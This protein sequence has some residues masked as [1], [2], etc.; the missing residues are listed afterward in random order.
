LRAPLIH[1]HPDRLLTA[2][3]VCFCAGTYDV[4]GLIIG[5]AIT[6]IQAFA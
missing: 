4:H 6:G 1:P 5:R 2:W 3:S